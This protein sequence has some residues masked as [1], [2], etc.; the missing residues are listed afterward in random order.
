MVTLS[1]PICYRT[2]AIL[3]STSARRQSS[4]YSYQGCAV[5]I[6][7]REVQVM[8]CPGIYAQ[9]NEAVGCREG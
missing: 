6:N 7:C 2:Q 9:L 5:H 8:N 3:S 1:E 4:I